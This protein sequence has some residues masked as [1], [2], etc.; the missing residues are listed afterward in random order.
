MIRLVYRM[1]F[2]LAAL[3]FLIFTS[4]TIRAQD[5]GESQSGDVGNPG[6]RLSDDGL[7]QAQ[8]H[9]GA[10]KSDYE[11]QL[12]DREA[13]LNDDIANVTRQREPIAAKID[14]M[15]NLSNLKTT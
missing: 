14:F 10:A 2:A 4:P 5:S 6:F 8:G 3:Q 11:G 1:S 13:K 15:N 12:Q 7:A 9:Y